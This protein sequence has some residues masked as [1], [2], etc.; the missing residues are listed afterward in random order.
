M[1]AGGEEHVRV[2]AFLVIT[3]LNN[4]VPVSLL[5]FSVKVCFISWL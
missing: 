1:W 2:L 3:K 4:I 5:D